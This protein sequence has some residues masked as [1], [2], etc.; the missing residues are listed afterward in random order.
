MKKITFK[1]L[2]SIAIILWSLMPTMAQKTYG[3]DIV[4]GDSSTINQ[5]NVSLAVAGNGWLYATFVRNIGTTYGMEVYKSTNNGLNWSSFYSF[6][7]VIYPVDVCKVIVCGAAPYKVMLGYIY[8]TTTN[9]S[10]GITEFDGTTNSIVA[11]RFLYNTAINSAFTDFDMVADDLFPSLG[12]SPYGVGLLYSKRSTYDSI[13]FVYSTNGGNNFGT[14]N[15]VDTTASFFG[16][17]SLAYGNSP[18]LIF[19]RYN[20]VWE[21]KDHSYSKTGHIQYSRTS[22]G[23]TGN[24]ITPFYLDNEPLTQNKCSNPKIACQFSS[25]DNDSSNVTAV[26]VFERWY[27]NSDNDVIG[28][29]NYK[30]S[31]ENIWNRFN[32]D[33]TNSNS[34]Q[35]DINYDSYFNN[36]LITY[37]DSTTNFL[38]YKVHSFNITTANASTWAVIT[39]NYNNNTSMGSLLQP[40]PVVEINNSLHMAAHLWSREGISGNGVVVFDAEYSNGIK[41]IISNNSKDINIYPNP[42]YGATNI[43]FELETS[44]MVLINAYDMAGKKINNLY[45]AQAP[46]GKNTVSINLS[47]WTDGNYVIEIVT[48]DF[49]AT[50]KLMVAH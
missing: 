15:F 35:P 24:F 2:A 16:K 39:A 8:H 19:G 5:R 21:E 44:S 38:P 41:E 11:Q 46:K 47:N 45:N 34:K 42:A 30:S 14:P 48:P 6:S 13:K 18:L 25:T 40:F 33:N 37:W 17:V 27:A 29:Y 7:S 3:Y 12:T 23:I 10:L 28:M 22:S 32:I 43:Q 4:V 1:T 36:F 31:S 26:V 50:K 20:A 9:Y 49:I